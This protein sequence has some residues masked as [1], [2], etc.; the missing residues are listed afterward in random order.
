MSSDG[1]IRS[2]CVGSTG[3]AS[4]AKVRQ[5]P[6]RLPSRKPANRQAAAPAYGSPLVSDPEAAWAALRKV[7]SIEPCAWMMLSFDS[8]KM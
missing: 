5:A 1:L 8:P 4:P 2:G 3:R 7:M 6:T